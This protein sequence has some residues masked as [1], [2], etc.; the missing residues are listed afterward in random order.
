MNEPSIVDSTICFKCEKYTISCDGRI[1]QGSC[2]NEPPIL[3]M[4]ISDHFKGRYEI[5]ISSAVWDNWEPAVNI[6]IKGRCNIKLKKSDV[7]VILYALDEYDKRVHQPNVNKCPKCGS[8]AI[9]KALN[10]GW[11]EYVC[12]T[13]MYD[14][15]DEPEDIEVCTGVMS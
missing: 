5:A 10:A 7:Q 6:K 12:S 14:W 8:F 4:S 3:K 2:K 9:Y 13:C 1:S 15:L 11:P